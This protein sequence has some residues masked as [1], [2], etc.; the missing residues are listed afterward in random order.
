MVGELADP[1]RIVLVAQFLLEGAQ[2]RLDTVGGMRDDEPVIRRRLLDLV[3]LQRR[4]AGGPARI[5]R[6]RIDLDP[7]LSRGKTDGGLQRL[8]R[9]LDGPLQQTVVPRGRGRVLQGCDS[10]LVPRQR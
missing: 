5:E 10:R 6:V 7:A 8:D 4:A 3:E 2:F 1:V 9:H